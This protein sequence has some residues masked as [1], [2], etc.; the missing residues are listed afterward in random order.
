MEVGLLTAVLVLAVVVWALSATAAV[1]GFICVFSGE[2]IERCGH[3]HRYR[4]TLAGSLP[5]DGCTP[6]KYE[7]LEHAS[8]FGHSH[9]HLHHR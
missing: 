8:S 2:R 5:K 6:G 9:L 4:I 7:R 1:V 3:C